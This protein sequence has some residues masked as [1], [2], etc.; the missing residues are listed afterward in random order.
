MTS[1]SSSKLLLPIAASFAA[2][3]LVDDNFV[4]PEWGG[5]TDHLVSGLVPLLAIGLLT[6]WVSLD[7]GDE[8][9]G[10]RAVVRIVL[11]VLGLM[12][13]SEA[14]YH[15]GSTGLAGDDWTGLAAA[16]VG[17]VMVADGVRHLWR[18]RRPGGTRV[19]R[20][21]RRGLKGLAAVMV[22]LEVGYPVVE[23][24]SVTNTADRS[25]PTW[26]LGVPVEDVTL[27]TSD[28]LT[29]RGWYV[30]SQNRAAVLVYPGR[31]GPQNQARLLIEHGY[32]V[33][34]IDR[35]GTGESDGEPNGWGW[36]SERDIHA[37]V[38][39]LQRRP[40]VDPA[41]IGGLGLSVGGE[42]LLQAAAEEDGL[43]AIVSEGAGIRSLNE[44]IEVDAPDKWL[45]VPLFFSSTVA[46]AIFSND[47]PPTGLT[48]LVPQIDIP[49]FFI[50]S[51]N[52]QG[53]EELS[54]RYYDLA[55]GPKQIWT[56]NGGHVGGLGADPI[57]Y[58]RRIVAF[59]DQWLPVV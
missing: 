49:T 56:P 20:Y 13:G 4:E 59:F 54:K 48:D 39:F 10:G 6:W 22:L 19:R 53:G 25:A 38:E 5:W 24:Y 52:G 3:H 57:E 34:L 36:G 31:A 42:L 58:E 30:P 12:L 9:T 55:R 41:R 11:G 8:R 15:V 33:L 44:L 21:T 2:V 16:A 7:R 26:S 40:D 1:R 37:A 27:R 47:L 18:S 45:L 32:G 46:T 50:Y 51:K 28:G 17:L 43:R 29:L 14:M 35:R 23:A